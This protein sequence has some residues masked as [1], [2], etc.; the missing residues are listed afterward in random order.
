MIEI[1]LVVAMPPLAF[2]VSA[3]LVPP[4]MAFLP[5]RSSNSP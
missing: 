4:I 2:V 5:S 3:M 1:M